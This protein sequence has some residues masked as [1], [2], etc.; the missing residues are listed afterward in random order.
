MAKSRITIIMSID[1]PRD[2]KAR[3]RRAQNRI[4]DDFN[5]RSAEIDRP[6]MV[7]F[8]T[9]IEGIADVLCR[10]RAVGALE[11]REEE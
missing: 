7:D 8:V 1:V 9:A 10:I 4:R 3:L 11:P 5:N 2:L 6:L